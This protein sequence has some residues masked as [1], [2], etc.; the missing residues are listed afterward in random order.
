MITIEEFDPSKFNLEKVSFAM[1]SKVFNVG[2]GNG[3]EDGLGN[4]PLWNRHLTTAQM[5]EIFW[6]EIKKYLPRYKRGE[7]PVFGGEPSW[8]RG[9]YFRQLMQIAEAVKQHDVKLIY[10][11]DSASAYAFGTL[12]YAELREHCEMIKRC[13]EYLVLSI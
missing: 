8:Y 10:Q 5:R 2:Q 6:N 11:G 1:S 4:S 3:V 9:M 12:R 13:I 7:L